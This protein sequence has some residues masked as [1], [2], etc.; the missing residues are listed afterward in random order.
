M[1]GAA[2]ALAPA[3]RIVRR[4]IMARLPLVPSLSLV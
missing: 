3:A 4:L 2:S 1:A